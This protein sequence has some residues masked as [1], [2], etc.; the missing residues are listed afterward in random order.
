M[1][2][3]TVLIVGDSGVGKSSYVK[4]IITGEYEKDYISTYGSEYYKMVYEAN[5]DKTTFDIMVLDG[6]NIDVDMPKVDAVIIM[7]GFNNPRTYLNADIKW[8]QYI[9]NVYGNVP[10][11]LCGNK[12]DMSKS[13]DENDSYI[14]MSV[15]TNENLLEPFSRIM[16]MLQGDCGMKWG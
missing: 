9:K 11:I 12:M 14:K 15:K 7:F 4:R 13:C 2:N 3:Y 10:M 1:S 16:K 5:M 6:L 8:R